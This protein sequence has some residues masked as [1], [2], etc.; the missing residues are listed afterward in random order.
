VA[1]KCEK[2]TKARVAGGLSF[3]PHANGREM[4]RGCYRDVPLG[5]AGRT[6]V[7]QSAGL[8]NKL[9]KPTHWNG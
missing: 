6:E 4:G 2:P 5:G 9:H 3:N 8:A 7:V 1:L